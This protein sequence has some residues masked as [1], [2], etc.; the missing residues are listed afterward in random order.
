MSGNVAG[1]E[2]SCDI[3]PEKV[4]LI[5]TVNSYKTDLKYE[6]VTITFIE[7]MVNAPDYWF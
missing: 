6:G 3:C 5:N 7:S 4:N 1:Y 2:I